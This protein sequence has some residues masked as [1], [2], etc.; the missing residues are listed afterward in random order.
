[1]SA[2]GVTIDTVFK[3]T[4][5]SRV[6]RER[7]RALTLQ[8][9]A[10]RAAF[11]HGSHQL[12]P[13]TQL[14][15]SLLH[16]VLPAVPRRDGAGRHRH[17]CRHIARHVWLVVEGSDLWG[18]GEGSS[19]ASVLVTTP[20]WHLAER[21]ELLCVRHQ[22]PP[23]GVLCLSVCFSWLIRGGVAPTTGPISSPSFG[24]VKWKEISVEGNQ[25]WDQINFVSVQLSC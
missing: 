19:L 23:M 11:F 13:Q 9:E 8:A 2:S 10:L 3:N 22:N 7:V 15:V 1:M 16:R 17:I 4:F 25:N 14:P 12:H 24:S 5:A 6:E 18:E 21:N 20:L